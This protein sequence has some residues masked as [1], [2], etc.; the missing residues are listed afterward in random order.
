MIKK[1]MLTIDYELFLGTKT[2]TVW[3]CMIEPT[4]KLV[5]IL[6]INGSKMTVFWDILHYYQLIKLE[7]KFPELKQDRILIEKQ[8]LDLA[9][10]GHD[11]QL[12]LHTHWLDAE[13]KDNQWVFNYDRFKLHNL[14]TEDNENDIN[15]IAGCISISKKILEDLIRKVR[16]EHKVNAFRAGGYLLEPF[17]ILKEAFQQNEIFIDS[18]VCPELVSENGVFSYDF[19]SYPNY[20]IYSF[21]S[22]P[23]KRK[24]TGKFKEIPIT[25]IKIPAFFNGL[26]R[27]LRKIK[28][29]KIESERGGSGTSGYQKKEKQ[30]FFRRLFSLFHTEFRQLTTDSTFKEL[31]R[32]QCRKAQ[33]YSTMILHPKL[34]NSHTLEILNEYITQNKIKFISIND[35]IN[36]SNK[37]EN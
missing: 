28:Y 26:F 36:N 19:R 4:E 5:S 34:L 24:D 27:L 9:E 33:Q 2:G 11:I 35:Y 37:T 3:E 18:S 25:T 21:D 31:F 32:Y 13:Y 16:P 6:S 23:M 8:I 29:A 22:S 1:F 10:K 17:A 20:N 7:N 30:Y 12:H 14:S 15:A